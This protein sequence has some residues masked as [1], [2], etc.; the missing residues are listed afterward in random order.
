MDSA[1]VSIE[2]NRL[3]RAKYYLRKI[4]EEHYHFF[5]EQLIDVPEGQKIEI[6]SGGGFIKDVIP[7]AITSDILPLP[8][9]EMVFSAIELPFQD[10]SLSSIF[11]LN[12]LHHI[13]DATLFFSEV[14][15]CLKPKGKV[16]MI[17]PANTPFSAFIYGKFH[18]EL[19]DSAQTG[20]TLPRGGRMSIANDALPWIIFLRDRLLFEQRF[21]YLKIELLKNFLPVRYIISGGLSKPQIL[22]SITY[23]LIKALEAGISPLNNILGLFMRIV[24]RKN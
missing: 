4:Y 11:M 23:P 1:S 13:Q 16:V 20:W 5:L 3:I 14:T 21:P 2:H 17:E 9:I 15:R 18:H 8:T 6:G 22:P 12:V 10:S 19:F 24:L 7:E